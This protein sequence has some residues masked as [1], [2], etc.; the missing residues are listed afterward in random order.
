VRNESR[1][2][3]EESGDQARAPYPPYRRIEAHVASGY[4]RTSAAGSVA[5][6]A[7]AAPMPAG[8]TPITTIRCATSALLKRVREATV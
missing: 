5:L 7:P 3:V 1:A 8:P 4:T 2:V 6:A